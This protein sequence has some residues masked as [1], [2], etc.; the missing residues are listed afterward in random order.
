MMTSEPQL[1]YKAISDPLCFVYEYDTNRNM[2][3]EFWGH[4]KIHLSK[5]DVGYILQ[6]VSFM[7]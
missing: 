4:E 6:M 7:I 3:W 1:Y 5:K 2:E